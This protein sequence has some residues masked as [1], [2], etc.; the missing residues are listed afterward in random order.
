MY[1]IIV[2]LH[3]NYLISIAILTAVG[4]IGSTKLYCSS[5]DASEAL[6][7]PSLY[8][9]IQGQA[10]YHRSGNF[11]VRKLSCK[12]FLSKVHFIVF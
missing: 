6:I 3:N 7:S 4:Q 10:T 9:I 12:P 2:V 11:S 5:M 8:C 1:V